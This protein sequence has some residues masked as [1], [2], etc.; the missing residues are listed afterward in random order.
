MDKINPGSLALSVTLGLTLATAVS[1]EIITDDFSTY[2]DQ[3]AF[4]DV[5]E[6]TTTGPAVI[7]QG[8]N[9]SL[10]VDF[11]SSGD[12]SVVRPE[13]FTVDAETPISIDLDIIGGSGAFAPTSFGIQSID[14]E[15]VRLIVQIQ[16]RSDDVE[17]LV[18][19]LNA[20]FKN[21]VIA[22]IA[23]SNNYE[24]TWRLSVGPTN[25]EVFHNGESVGANSHDLNYANYANGAQVFLSS[26]KGWSGGGTNVDNLKIEGTQ[27]PEPSSLAL[28]GLAGLLAS[29]RG[30]H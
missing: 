16:R 29:R 4:E 26:S 22:S 27:V 13:A 8:N 7:L 28:L 24:A 25:V 2:A 20:S 9:E 14:D 17:V 11:S 6:V 21:R 15:S 5:Y 10:R 23:N 3:T 19:N 18:R 30:Q 1:G 12:A